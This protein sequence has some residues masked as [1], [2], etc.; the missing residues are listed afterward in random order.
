MSLLPCGEAND[1]PQRHVIKAA[2][3]ALNLWIIEGVE[4]VI[5]EPLTVDENGVLSTDEHDNALGG[6]RSPAVDVPI[7][8]LK[9]R[10]SATGDPNLDLICGL[11]GE[12]IPFTPEK[13]LALYPTHED[14][15]TKIKESAQKAREAKFLLEPEEQAI[16]A[17]AEAAP[18]PI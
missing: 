18:V 9:G 7:A 5:G 8:T 11:F 4:P 17:E 12:T 2:M 6:I 14:Y 1:G 3:H 10:T 15:V 13:L 16:V